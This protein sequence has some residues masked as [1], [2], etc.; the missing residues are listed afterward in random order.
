MVRNRALWHDLTV[1]NIPMILILLSIT[2]IVC[3][4]SIIATATSLR[5]AP[6]ATEDEAGF[7]TDGQS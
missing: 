7:H 1:P 6:V 5:G 2:F 4:A 3:A